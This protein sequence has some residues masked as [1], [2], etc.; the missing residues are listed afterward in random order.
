MPLRCGGFR[1]RWATN[2][3]YPPYLKELV[4][5][6]ERLELSRPKALVSRTNVAP[7]YTTGPWSA[8]PDSNWLRTGLQ[9]AA[10]TASAF[11]AEID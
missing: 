2:C 3:P 8:E 4:V 10:S 9:A 1:D 5:G 7:N 11:S 6:R